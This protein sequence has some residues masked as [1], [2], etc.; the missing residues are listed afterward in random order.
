MQ[1]APNNQPESAERNPDAATAD[2]DAAKKDALKEKFGDIEVNEEQSR[3]AL[4]D[5]KKL[6]AVLDN[7]EK[8][9]EQS[10]MKMMI[11]PSMVVGSMLDKV[12]SDNDF[13]KKVID[14][15][16]LN[17]NRRE[18]LGDG[19]PAAQAL[20]RVKADETYFKDIY[21]NANKD[22][23][24]YD[25][26]LSRIDEQDFLKQEIDKVKLQDLGRATAQSEA[27]TRVTDQKYLSETAANE[28]VDMFIRT[29]A[30][31]KLNDMTLLQKYANFTDDETDQYKVRK[32]RYNVTEEEWTLVHEAFNKFLLRDAARK[33]LQELEK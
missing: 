4:T 33:R 25:A 19:N 27:I 11:N 22:S 18:G 8:Q 7:F 17:Y 15:Y 12:A 6:A 9:R 29:E 31:S 30:I 21:K 24:E 14:T 20:R 10:P 5:P 28:K 16:L 3:E 13:L 23:R 32:D 26:A 1:D 2:P